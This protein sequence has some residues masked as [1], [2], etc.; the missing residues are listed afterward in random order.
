MTTAPSALLHFLEGRALQARCDL[1]HVRRARSEFSKALIVDEGFAPAHARIA[2]TLFVEWILCGGTD[3]ELLSAARQRA[4]QAVR[5][6]PAGPT[7]HW[8]SGAVAL[9]QRQW[10]KVNEAYAEAESLAP[11]DADMLLEYGDALSHLGDH[12][13]AEEKFSKA[14]DLNPI[15]PDRY[16]WFGA[17]IA[18]NR[19]DFATAADRCDRISDETVALG[20]RTTSYANAGRMD[21]ARKWARRLKEALPDVKADHLVQLS[22][23]RDGEVANKAYVDGLRMAGVK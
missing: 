23:D 9:Y 22:P 11:H 21:D 10:D 8:V 3:A 19:M 17:S 12:A 15:P 6:E 18:F 13:A 5:L 1:P 16:L 7:G 20:L 14:I 2:E 4:Q